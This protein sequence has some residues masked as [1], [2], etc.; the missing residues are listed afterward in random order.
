MFL[1]DSRS[2]KDPPLIPGSDGAGIIEAVGQGVTG[3]AIGM[4]VIIN[5]SLRWDKKDLPPALPEILGGP[6]DGTLAQ[7]VI[8]P[9]KNAFPKPQYLSWVEAGVLS[10]SALTAYRA[11]FTRGNLQQGQHVLIPGIGGGVATIAALMA[12]AAGARVSVTS[13]KETTLKAALNLHADRIFHS[14]DNWEKHL[15]DDP[16]DLIL[17]SIGSAIFHKYPGVMKPNGR[18][19]MF[20]ASSGEEVTF[21]SRAIFYPQIQM[22]GTSMGSEEEYISMLQFVEKHQIHPFVDTV[23]SLKD[24]TKAF[25]SMLQGD[26]FGKIAISID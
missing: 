1:L 10:L 24:A 23:Y 20:G 26:R 16:A 12:K 3:L 14:S 21:S 17:D 8:V 4:E 7:S 6:I 9:Q 2:E 11:L 15:K 13:R 22:I 5:P 18:I 25:S 19:V